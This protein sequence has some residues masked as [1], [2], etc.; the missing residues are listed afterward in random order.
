MEN[1]RTTADWTAETTLQVSDRKIAMITGGASGI[2]RA[3]CKEAAAHGMIVIVTDI[4]EEGGR[5][6]VRQIHE[7]GQVEAYFEKL[8]VSSAE[9]VQD[10]V[11]RV[12][13]TYGRLDYM[14]N[15]AGIAMYGEL[16]DMS[17]ELWHKIVNI[18]L[19]GAIHG[20]H[21]V[22]PLMKRQGF[23]YIVNTSS[24]TGLGPA[25]MTSAY[26]TTKHAVVGLTTSLH[27]EAEAYGVHVS[28]LCPAFVDT[29]I[30]AAADA[31]GMDK[32]KINEQVSK[33]KSMS[34][35]Q[36]AKIAFAKIHRNEAVICPMP[37]RRTMDIFFILFPALH[38]K[39]MRLVCRISREA[40]LKGKTG[41]PAAETPSTT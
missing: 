13:R 12:F 2:G 20:T 5:E 24:A 7:A 41:S 36:F 22:Y 33:Q 32:A 11:N 15:N 21:A 16:C 27:Y 39:L 35:E 14:F 6:T 28:A 18:N 40:S 17:L 37:M 38:R 8:D 30:Y 29:P 23:G 4:N 10:L 26:A 3:L 9:D 25:P 34:P 19:W 31:V 1:Q